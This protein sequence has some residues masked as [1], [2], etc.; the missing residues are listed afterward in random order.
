MVRRAVTSTPSTRIGFDRSARGG[1]ILPQALAL[2]A[3]IFL[4]LWLLNIRYR[5]VYVPRLDDVTALADALLMLP[6]SHWQDWFTQGHS[7]FFDAYPEWP[8]GLT[9]FA[10]PIFQ[11]T[12]YLAHF[13]F[14]SHWGSYL[15]I[16]YL[17]VAGPAA[18]AFALARGALRLDLTPSLAAAVLTLFA[19]AVTEFSIWEIGFGSEPLASFFL[20][21]GFLALV[22]RRHLLCV[23][24]LTVALLTKE[25]A[26]WA[27]LAAAVTVLIRP[28]RRRS[29]TAA[30]MLLPIAVW[31][32]LR[33]VF[34][35]GIDGTYASPHYTPV[36]DFL[37]VTGWKLTHFHHLLVSRD[38][39]ISGG[40][41][42]L[43]D[44]AAH[45]GTAAF[46]PLL[47]A[48]W[49]AGAIRSVV[50]EIKEALRERRAIALDDCSVAT[51]WAAAGLGFY[52]ALTLPDLRYATG[53][54]MF[55]WP[56][57]I[58]AVT[59][60]RNVF[61][62]LGV[63]AC[64]LISLDR[65]F[66]Y[67]ASLNPP[68]AQSN[69]AKLFTAVTRMNDA[70]QHL[71]ENIRQVYVLSAG[72]D[73]SDVAPAYLRAFLGVK[74]EIVRVID[75]D[76]DCGTGERIDF[77]H[78]ETGGMVTLN[79]TLPS[80]AQFQ[81]EGAILDS[82]QLIGGTLQRSPAI[83][84]ELPDA[85]PIEN[86][87]PRSQIFDLGRRMTVSIRPKGPARFIIE[88]SGPDG[89]LVWFDTLEVTPP[90]GEPSN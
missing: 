62:Q 17:S 76:W 23:L 85:R 34:F 22:A 5:Q 58:A 20:G 43:L 39:A 66:H 78:R 83:T 89:D 79:A 55:L 82:R 28:G 42:L 1:S 70:L 48:L 2:G 9:A 73:L 90:G 46:V 29:T 7:H 69:T 6:G 21:C 38:Y 54:V 86:R 53:A 47:L 84:Y 71:P 36:A 51:L 27:P 49:L 60:N 3:G 74:A 64:F 50:S 24:L 25:T 75:T 35:G 41:W 26:I 59:R 63:A 72:D 31:L 44:R 61:L 10:R 45:L 65:G 77:T 33:F 56:V 14:G 11:C 80:C 37:A 15:A 57:L 18:V 16:N 40:R 30:A 88:P 87:A 12:I 68:P 52:F 19:P 81:F 67:I 8:W 32:L 4:L 13:L